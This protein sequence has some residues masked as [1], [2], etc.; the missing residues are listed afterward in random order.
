MFAV[1]FLKGGNQAVILRFPIGADLLVQFGHLLLLRLVRFPERHAA[2]RQAADQTSRAASFDPCFCGFG[3][4]YFRLRQ[5][6]RGSGYGRAGESEDW[7]DGDEH[8]ED[9]L[10]NDLR[11]HL[12]FRRWRCNV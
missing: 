6:E 12:R 11:F 4:D 8:V 3:N 10:E 9:E 2:E 5:P 7:F 1:E